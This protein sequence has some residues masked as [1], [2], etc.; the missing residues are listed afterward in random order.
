[1]IR[2]GLST[3]PGAV[4]GSVRAVHPTNVVNAAITIIRLG[5]TT[6]TLSY[7]RCK[8]RLKNDSA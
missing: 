2:S 8:Y 6:N 5:R 1:M 3:V 4:A 7:A